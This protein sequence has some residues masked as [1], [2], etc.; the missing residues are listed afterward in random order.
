[1]PTDTIAT[2]ERP[3]VIKTHLPVHML[4]DQVWTVKPKIIYVSRDV[5]DVAI[6]FYYFY[7]DVYH[8]TVELDDFLEAFMKDQVLYSPY[9]EHKEDYW[10]LR[11]FNN[12]LF[13]KYEDI[14]SDND[15]T[16]SKVC[17]FLG[18]PISTYNLQKLKEHLKFDSMKSKSQNHVQK[19]KP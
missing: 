9:K 12:I 10:K 18:K 8:S 16:I 6:S 15:K 4:P 1:M 11:N 5:K 3:R 2:L 17:N 14:I 19:R 7:K 13:L